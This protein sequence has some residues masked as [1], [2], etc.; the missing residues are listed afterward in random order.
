MDHVGVPE[1]TDTAAVLAQ[2][3]LVVV[4]VVQGSLL[5]VMVMTLLRL[6]EARIATESARW[7]RRRRG[8][9]TILVLQQDDP[10][11]ATVDA[12]TV[13]LRRV[14]VRVRVVGV[15]M[16]LVVV[17]TLRAAVDEAGER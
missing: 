2:R 12:A 3:M 8:L 15:L 11:A 7:W 10:R 17:Q 13:C 16:V 6:A 1:D 5:L 4:G 9:G 14:T